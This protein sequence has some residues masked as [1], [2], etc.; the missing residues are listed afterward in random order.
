MSLQKIARHELHGDDVHRRMARGDS[1]TFHS[2]PHALPF[3]ALPYGRFRGEPSTGLAACGC[4][5]PLWPPH[6]VQQ[7]SSRVSKTGGNDF[8]KS[9]DDRSSI[10]TAHIA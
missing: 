3:Y 10:H 4:L 7:K 6:V 2:G 9:N 8:F 5:L 1:V